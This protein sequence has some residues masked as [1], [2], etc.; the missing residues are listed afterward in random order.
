MKRVPSPGKGYD[1]VSRW[2][3]CGLLILGCVLQTK[4]SRADLGE[5]PFASVYQ[6]Y[7]SQ[8]ESSEDAF[9]DIIGDSDFRDD[10]II[11]DPD[12]GRDLVDAMEPVLPNGSVNGMISSSFDP[13]LLK[14]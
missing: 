2:L 4:I 5:I 12:L 1:S 8:I 14:T 9:Q 10:Q 13:C 6:G 11:Q 7:L 3:F